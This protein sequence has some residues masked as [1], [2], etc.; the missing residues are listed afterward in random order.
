LSTNGI[1]IDIDLFPDRGFPIINPSKKEGFIYRG[2]VEFPY[3]EEITF[4][5]YGVVEKNFEEEKAIFSIEKDDYYS[6]HKTEFLA[7][8]RGY[9]KVK[10]S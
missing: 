8:P 4:V 10:N 2:S 1:S 7:D 3:Q 5:F 6:P 9:V